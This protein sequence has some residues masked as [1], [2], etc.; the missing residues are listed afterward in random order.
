MHPSIA[1]APLGAPP[2]PLFLHLLLLRLRPMLKFGQLYTCA[3][4]LWTC[5][6]CR[7]PLHADIHHMLHSTTV[8]STMLRFTPG[9]ANPCGISMHSLEQLHVVYP[10]VFWKYAVGALNCMQLT[11]HTCMP[12]VSNIKQHSLADC[13]TGHYGQRLTC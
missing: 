5:S 10:R 1:A 6:I 7:R 3:S 9:P 8:K 13:A 4:M 12:L 2:L 11:Q